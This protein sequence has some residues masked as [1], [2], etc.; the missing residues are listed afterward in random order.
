MTDATPAAE[1]PSAAKR[2]THQSRPHPGSPPGRVSALLDDGSAAELLSVHLATQA[3]DFLR[4]LPSVDLHTLRRVGAALHTFESLLD[5]A[6]AREM[7]EELSRL[8]AVLGQERAYGRRL[9]RLLAGLDSLTSTDPAANAAQL[10]AGQLPSGQL[11]AA[12]A[13][14][15][16]R[17]REAEGLLARHP[18]A[19]KARALLER[20]LTLGRSRAH[21]AALQELG[22][23]RFHAL[24][25][26]MTLLVSD[27]P[28]RAGGSDAPAGEL[29]SCAAAEAAALTAAAEA[30]PLER[31]A[32]AYN[33]DCLHE[34]GDDQ[35]WRQ[36]HGMVQRTRYAL[37]LCAPLLGRQAGPPL[38]ALTE[39]GR[40]LGRHRDAAEA[41]EAA[42]LAALTPRITPATGYVLGVVHADQRLEVEATRHAFGTTWPDLYRSGWLTDAWLTTR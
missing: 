40:I 12:T 9:S 6:W 16:P 29:L 1:A 22:S 18:G 7:R 39:L 21:T 2:V 10:P 13:G 37:E 8:G 4:G 17:P 26:R 23:A 38:A 36:V 24:A 35:P 19:P 15:V 32:V 5:P 30:L 34:P 20:Q 41:A 31:A 3:G 25:D 28:L 33:G 27:L 11:P 14:P 42:A